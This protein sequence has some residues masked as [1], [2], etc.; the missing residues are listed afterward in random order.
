[1]AISI[2]VG[3]DNDIQIGHPHVF[4][5]FKPLQIVGVLSQLHNAINAINLAL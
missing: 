1:M 3:S 4:F 2:N 5:G